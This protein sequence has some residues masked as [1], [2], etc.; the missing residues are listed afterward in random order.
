MTNWIDHHGGA[1]PVPPETMVEIKLDGFYETSLVA[2][3][4][5]PITTGR[6]DEF[7]WGDDLIVSYRIIDRDTT[8]PHRAVLLEQAK[9]IICHDRQDV[10][11]RPEDTF[12]LISEYWTCY[13]AHPISAA[14][15][16]VMMTLFKVARL[17][18]NPG[19][20]DNVTDGIGYLAIAGELIERAK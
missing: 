14:D 17:Q 15:V 6:A 8:I 1:M 16:A 20:E 10:H 4:A 13:L 2:R 11:G 7:V 18:K 19:H 9:Q 5:K 3:G 12:H